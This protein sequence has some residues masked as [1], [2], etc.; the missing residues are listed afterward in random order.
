MPF[1]Y[2]RTGEKFR[3][4]LIDEFQDTSVL[5]WNNLLPLVENSLSHNGSNM[6]VGDGKQAI[7]RFR[8]GEVEQFVRLPE[9]KN[10]KS[11]PIIQ[12]LAQALAREYSANHL[13]SNFRSK[14]EVVEFNNLFF[15]YVANA[16]LL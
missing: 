1:I 4:Y 16:F 14:C 5:Q 11:N 12:Q 6:I 7:Y 15:A 8:N 9:I 2:E 13:D 10:P 3:H